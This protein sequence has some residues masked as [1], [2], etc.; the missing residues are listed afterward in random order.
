MQEVIQSLS[1]MKAAGEIRGF[2]IEARCD[3]TRFI[4]AESPD[5]GFYV[6]YDERDN[7]DAE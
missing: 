6:I 5:G 2:L 7:G 4:T 3:G 1:T